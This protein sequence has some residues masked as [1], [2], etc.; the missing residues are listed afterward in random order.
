MACPTDSYSRLVWAI[1]VTVT[2]V[3]STKV[4]IRRHRKSRRILVTE[5]FVG[6]NVAAVHWDATNFREALQRI[7]DSKE[8]GYELDIKLTV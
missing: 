5:E 6:G 7:L 2:L 8:P 1:V 3:K 4:K